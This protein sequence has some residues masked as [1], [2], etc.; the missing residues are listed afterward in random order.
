MGRKKF[1]GL[2]AVYAKH[3]GPKPRTVDDLLH[4]KLRRRARGA[5][6]FNKPRWRRG[7]SGPVDPR[8]L[9]ALRRAKPDVPFPFEPRPDD[10]LPC[11][12]P[13][14]SPPLFDDDGSERYRSHDD[15]YEDS[16]EDGNDDD[17]STSSLEHEKES[18]EYS[19]SDD[20]PPTQLVVPQDPAQSVTPFCSSTPSPCDSSSPL[21]EE[22]P[23]VVSEDD[24][25]DG[26]S[27]PSHDE[28]A[29][30]R[31]YVFCLDFEVLTS[32]FMKSLA[33]DDDDDEACVR[34]GASAARRTSIDSAAT[35]PPA[36]SEDDALA[37]TLLA[38]IEKST[39]LKNSKRPR[40]TDPRRKRNFG[41]ELPVFSLACE[42]FECA[43]HEL[44]DLS[45]DAGPA[46]NHDA[47]IASNEAAATEDPLYVPSLLEDLDDHKCCP[48]VDSLCA[49]MADKATGL[50]RC[51]ARSLVDFDLDLL[52]HVAASKSISVWDC[53]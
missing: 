4:I 39:R 36:I 9:D 24:V 41:L 47:L 13:D 38:S 3:D 2:D 17:T 43:E 21:F 33:R 28:H 53:L 5:K 46:P 30:D 19:T 7:K 37:G 31:G 6:G 40:A 1:P 27:L 10:P 15:S 18:L 49:D 34:I 20:E 50:P 25:G 12:I 26:P 52:E 44:K 11:A 16:C 14:F 45:R 48:L 35:P 29:D 23:T 32:C 51:H 8:E 22:G 42:D